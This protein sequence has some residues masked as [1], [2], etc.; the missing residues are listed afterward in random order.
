[1]VLP[2]RFW[3]KILSQRQFLDSKDKPIV[4]EDLEWNCP[5]CLIALCG[6]GDGFLE[7]ET[8]HLKS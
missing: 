4:L 5:G 7:M 1:M 6:D 2:H 8:T 3:K